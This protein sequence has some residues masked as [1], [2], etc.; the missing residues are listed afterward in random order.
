MPNE[1]HTCAACSRRSRRLLSYPRAEKYFW[2]CHAC[3]QA[4]S[5]AWERAVRGGYAIML[6]PDLGTPTRA[7]SSLPPR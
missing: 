2:I 1:R 5:L 7:S 3:A 4:I 6:S